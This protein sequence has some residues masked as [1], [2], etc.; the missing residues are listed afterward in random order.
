MLKNK[1]KLILIISL[2]LLQSITMG[3]GVTKTGTTAAKF[4]SI[5]IGPRA[6]AMGGSFTSIANDASAMYWNPSGISLIEKKQVI[7]TQTQWI[8]DIKINYVGLVVPFSGIGS[9]GVNVT[10]MTMGDME[11]TTEYLP[12]GTGDKFS[13]GMYAFGVSYARRLTQNF[14]IGANIKY[15]REDISNSSAQGIALDLGTLFITPFYGIRFSSSISNFGTKMKMSGDDL[16]FQ[17]DPDPQRH[18]NNESIDAYYDTDN[19]DMP[20]RLQIGMSRDFEFTEGQVLTLAVDGAHPNDNSE[21]VNLGAELALLNN[22]VFLRG[23]FKTLFMEDR[24]EGLT[25]GAG[26]NFNRSNYFGIS[27]DYAF[28][29]FEHLGDIHTFGFLL[30]F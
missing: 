12:E 8:A 14:M 21:F 7:F 29:N 25:L 5:G 11:R 24:E 30:T 2:T 9:I 19:F 23:G 20:L 17:H 22:M 28:Q 13:A 26:Y 18:G 3:K 1:L 4:L 10:A 27:I 6:I 15:V 16:L